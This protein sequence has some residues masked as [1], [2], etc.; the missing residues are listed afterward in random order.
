MGTELLFR[1]MKMHNIV[2]VPRST[3]VYTLKQWCLDHENYISIVL[4]HFK[5]L[6]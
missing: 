6:G 4:I 2:T 3:E 1:G 5:G